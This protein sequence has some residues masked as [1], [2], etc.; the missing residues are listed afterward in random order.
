MCRATP[1]AIRSPAV[2]VLL[3]CGFRDARQRAVMA[4][5]DT[6]GR[7]VSLVRHRSRRCVR[8]VDGDVAACSRAVSQALATTETG[9]TGAIG[10][11]GEKHQSG[12]PGE[13][14]PAVA[15]GAAGTVAPARMCAGGNEVGCD[16]QGMLGQG[17]VRDQVLQDRLSKAVMETV[18]RRGETL[19]LDAVDIRSGHDRFDLA[20]LG[21]H[22]RQPTRVHP[23][24]DRDLFQGRDQAGGD[25][26]RGRDR[27]AGHQAA[28]AAADP[29]APDA[30]T[31]V[32]PTKP[33]R[34]PV[35]AGLPL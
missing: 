23:L 31:G 20:G 15:R 35:H 17:R 30:R 19:D 8:R 27:P 12:G 22:R 1:R 14:A 33:A 18:T 16:R 6:Q 3:S 13:L 4:A 5:A 9:P 29:A 25:P 10:D 32:R 28:Y 26:G 2:T 24:A 7:F 34:S 11:A 21:R